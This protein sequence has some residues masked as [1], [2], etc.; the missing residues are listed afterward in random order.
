MKFK[1]NVANLLRDS[2]NMNM[3]ERKSTSHAVQ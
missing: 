3:H 2:Y 1:I